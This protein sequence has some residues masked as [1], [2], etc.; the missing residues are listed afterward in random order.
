MTE[1]PKKLS[2]RDAIKLI[3]AAAGASVLANLP[4]KW[5]KPEVT[6]GVLPAHAQTSPASVLPTV[7]T[8]SIIVPGSPNPPYADVNFTGNVTNEGSTPVTDRGFVWNTSP[9]ATL[10]VNYGSVSTGT[11]GLGIFITNGEHVSPINSGPTTFYGRAY[12]TNSVGTSYG[13]DI[14][15]QT[16]ICLV[17]GTLITLADGTRKKIEDIDYSDQLLV[18]NFDEGHFDA[19]QP[20][21]IKKAEVAYQYNLLEFSDGSTL[22]TINQHRIFNKELGMF[23]YPMTEDTPLG[24]TTFNVHGR[25]VRLTGKRV[26]IEQV[27]YYN[28][29][30]YRHM[31]LF[32]D[33]ILTSCRYNNIYPIVDMKFVK[34]DRV[35]VPQEQYGLEDRYY[36][37]MRLAEQSIAVADTIAYVNR[38]KALDMKRQEKQPA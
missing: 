5:T 26:V 25:E 9:N 12:A 2:R 36:E 7:A 18:W 13:S 6:A 22:K 14:T 38:L 32:A 15:F 30:T 19:A 23:T 11:G 28:V 35:L 37:G 21:W 24:T 8:V 3:G 17:E 31:N 33:G 4:S 29:I 27:N 20:L 10:G 1:Q 16:E 34:D